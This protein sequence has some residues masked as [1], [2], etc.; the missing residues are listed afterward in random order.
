M[1]LG[2]VL[3][4]EYELRKI[5]WILQHHRSTPR[6]IGYHGW[7]SAVAN[8]VRL[9]VRCHLIIAHEKRGCVGW[10]AQK[11]V[12]ERWRGA[13]GAGGLRDVDDR[14]N[15]PDK[16]LACSL[17]NAGQVLCEGREANDTSDIGEDGFRGKRISR[18]LDGV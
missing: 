11:L 4:L 2:I 3:R 13:A 9:V 17:V 8:D 1:R 10:L 14:S 16:S 6:E 18:V 5:G 15:Q 12:K 7:I